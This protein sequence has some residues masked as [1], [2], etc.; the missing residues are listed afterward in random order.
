MVK[1]GKIMLEYRTEQVEKKVSDIF[2]CDMC[3]K[4]LKIEKDFLEY[5]ES[6]SIKFTAGYNSIFGDENTIICD[7]C[8][9][10]LKELI[11]DFYRV[12]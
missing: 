8:Q 12:V 9:Y 10:C 4:R 11:D 7:L 1:G 6:Y 3:G 2:I 5:Q